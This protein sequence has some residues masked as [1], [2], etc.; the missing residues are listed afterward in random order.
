MTTM[1]KSIIIFAILLIGTILGS[2]AFSNY[3]LL[4]SSQ[5]PTQESNVTQPP[6]NQPASNPTATPQTFLKPTP[7]T[8]VIPKPSIIWGIS[9]N[10]KATDLKVI[11]PI[12]NAAYKTNTIELIYNI[13]SKVLWSY[14][15]IDASEYV[16]IQHLTNDNGWISFKGNI[17]LNLSEGQHRL[18]IAVQT[19]ESRGSSVPI[20]Y[21]TIDFTINTTD[22]P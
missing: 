18:K 14:Y 11:S 22:V 3:Y 4:K 20:A 2:A 5:I 9:P 17:T 7:T 19:E 13:N 8:T 16:D 12:N 1:K 15:S 6:T 10:N 21:Q